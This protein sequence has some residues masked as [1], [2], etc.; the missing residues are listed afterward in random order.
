MRDVNPRK[1]RRAVSAETDL[2]Q[3]SGMAKTP[4]RVRRPKEVRE[5]V[6]AAA[7]HAFATVGFEGASTRAIANDAQVTQSLLLYHFKTKDE[8]WRAVLQ[9]I[10]SMEKMEQL[11]ASGDDTMTAAQRLMV[12]IR[13]LVELFAKVPELH[14]L[15]TLEAHQPSERLNWIIEN[16]NRAPYEAM[17]DLIAEAQAEG[18]VRKISP[19]RLRFAIVGMAAV[20][21]S[22]SAEY[23][24]LTKRNPF[25]KIE[26]EATIDMICGMIF[27]QQ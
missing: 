12:A 4:R 8:L 7:L 17:C 13:A 2:K 20:P 24:F 14:R 18:A 11:L 16:V 26:I 6:L 5:R 23:Q 22:V 15:M 9:D 27:I 25:S 19:E 21:F 10:A 1:A 3:P